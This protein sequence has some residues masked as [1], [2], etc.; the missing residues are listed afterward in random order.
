[1]RTVGLLTL[2][3]AM[4]LMAAETVYKWVDENGEVQYGHAVPPEHVDQAYER[5]SEGV[6]RESVD[7][8]MTEEERAAWK[9]QQRQKRREEAARKTQDSQDKLLLAS[10]ESEDEIVQSMETELAMVRS[11]EGSLNTSLTN[12]QSRYRQLIERAAAEQRTGGSVPAATTRAIEE[13]RQEIVRQR[14]SLKQLEERMERTRQNYMQD[15]ERYRM[16]SQQQNPA[17]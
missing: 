17:G 1:M 13:T 16:L 9:A 8:A 14:A 15:L 10:Y 11:Q 2:L 5:L 12:S 6:V 7:R 3:L 4:P